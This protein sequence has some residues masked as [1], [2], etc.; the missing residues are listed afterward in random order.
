MRK[1]KGFTLIE[2]LVTMVIVSLGL[3]GIAGIIANSLKVNQGAYTRSQASWLANDVI[4]RMRSNRVA[5]ETS[6][7]PYAL[8]SCGA[9]PAAPAT[10]AQ[11]DLKQWC[12]ALV[13]SLPSGTGTGSITVGAA[14]S[15]KV[16]VVVQW[17]DS[18]QAGG[19]STQQF[20]VETVL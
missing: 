1:Q 4:D 10:V 18:R 16:T 8:A 20:T 3:L 7:S 11:T 9:A 6:P 12:D 19:S 15:R 13:A 5:A 17:D 14:P 2:V